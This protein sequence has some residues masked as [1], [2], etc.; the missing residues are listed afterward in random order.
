MLWRARA[1]IFVVYLVLGLSF[2]VT[3]AMLAVEYRDHQWFD[4]AVLHS[5]LFVF[6]PTFGIVTLFAF[7]TPACALTDMYWRHE[8]FGI[9]R[10]LLGF[11]VVSV[12]SFLGAQLL[13]SSPQRSIWEVA[14][15]VL[16]SDQGDPAGC[17]AAGA[18][19]ARLPVMTVIDNVRAV[20]RHRVGLSDLA[21]RCE[22]DPF[23]AADPTR[24]AINRYCA[25]ASRLG[26]DGKPLALVA[27]ADCC[28]AQSRFVG[29]LGDMLTEPT[30]RSLTGKIATWT[31]PFKVFFLIT[32]IVI[33]V[34][35]AVRHRVLVQRYT[36]FVERIERGII[37]GALAML[38]YPA[39]NHAYLNSAE[40]FYGTSSASVFRSTAPLYSI[41]FGAWALLLLLFFYRRREREMQELGRIIGV[42]G[43][44]IAIV[45]YEA[46][47]DIFGHVAG[48][49][50]N[51]WSI[52]LIGIAAIAAIVSLYFKTMQ[53]LTLAAAVIGLGGATRA[54]TVMPSTTAAAA[55]IASEPSMA[56]A[57]AK[58]VDA[59]G[60]GQ[61]GS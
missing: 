40:L 53:D 39:M 4:I 5:Q 59:G 43:S 26:P 42:I 6:F 54:A 37:I 19:C 29:A 51:E 49:G 7:Y 11:V 9:L 8:K 60:E 18:P 15:Q 22:P 45:K 57:I 10:F 21:R 46:I 17:A 31:L 38:F 24:S 28:R 14:P 32:L 12:L 2:L 23:V 47:I 55:V 27:D 48:S 36:G 58:V 13:A 3:P 41:G 30:A 1:F 50:A 34:L 35:L 25:V 16:A 61:G 20:S 44:A 33:S 56:D 52:A